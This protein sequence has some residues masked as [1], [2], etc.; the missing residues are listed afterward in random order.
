MRLNGWPL[1]WLALGGYYVVAAIGGSHLCAVTLF[2]GFMAGRALK[3]S[4]E[5]E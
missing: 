2:A 5:G 1:L 4:T 3:R